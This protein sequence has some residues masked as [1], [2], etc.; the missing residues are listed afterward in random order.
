MQNIYL[1]KVVSLNTPQLEGSPQLGVVVAE[2]L[3]Q[4]RKE[5]SDT[6]STAPLSQTSSRTSSPLPWDFLSA[7]F[8]A[9]SPSPFPPRISCLK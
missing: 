9:S 6:D 2:T 8:S 5:D 7:L 4:E 3:G 1:R